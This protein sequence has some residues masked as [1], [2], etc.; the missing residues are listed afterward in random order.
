MSDEKESLMNDMFIE[1][2]YLVAKLPYHNLLFIAMARCNDLL[3][4]INEIPPQLF[5]M[6]NQLNEDELKQNIINYCRAVD[7]LE[8]NIGHLLQNKKYQGI[9]DQINQIPVKYPDDRIKQ[10]MEKHRLL[11]IA[12]NTAG[13][14]PLQSL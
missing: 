5:P 4:R 9:T 14:L 2:D 1:Q 12:I 13:L 11:V 8:I 10:A 6:I 7:A 3:S